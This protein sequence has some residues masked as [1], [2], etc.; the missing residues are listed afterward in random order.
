[1]RE[2]YFNVKNIALNGI[3][4]AVY[5]VITIACGPLSYEFMQLRFSELLNLLVFFNPSFTVG[6][7]LGCLL[8]NLASSLGPLDIIFGT[9]T[10]FVAC[11][12]MVIYSRFIK[13]LFS[14]GF[15]PCILNAVV[16]PFTIYLTT[17][18]TS[19]PMVL[20]AGLYFTMF[21]WVFLGEFAC[22]IVIGYPL[23]LLLSK[24][25]KRFYSLILATRNTD[26]KW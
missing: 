11:V 6:L 8:A 21:G 7:T 4:A 22:I 25:N 14:V 3:I 10:T 26:Y 13:N 23:F 19:E 18:N 1:M 17:I 12:I 24:K 5:A 20:D 9:L 16:V 15:I 2:K